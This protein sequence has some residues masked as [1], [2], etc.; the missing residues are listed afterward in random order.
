MEQSIHLG[1]IMQVGDLVRHDQG[2]IGIIACIDPEQIGD[3]DEVEV[4]WNDGDI[5]IMSTWNLELVC[6]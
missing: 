6:K 2:Y 1:G 3:D 4:V 5:C